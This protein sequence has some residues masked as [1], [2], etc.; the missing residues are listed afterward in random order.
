MKYFG[1]LPIILLADNKNTDT[2]GAGMNSELFPVLFTGVLI[3]LCLIFLLVRRTIR[4]RRVAGILRSANSYGLRPSANQDA[5]IERLSEQGFLLLSKIGNPVGRRVKYLLEGK[6]DGYKVHLFDYEVIHLHESNTLQSILVLESDRGR[7]PGFALVPGKLKKERFTQ[8]LRTAPLEFT[9]RLV[10]R[11]RKI[12]SKVDGHDLS[13]LPEDEHAVIDLFSE[14]LISY[15]SGR[16]K[17]TVEGKG[18]ALLIYQR[19]RVISQGDMEG[20]VKDGIS[21]YQSFSNEKLTK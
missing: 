17:Y 20:F 15:F 16:R 11:Y 19:E 4:K 6:V 9:S 14:E 7:F 18:K 10:S 1:I 21:I 5:A 3:F 12:H 13:C 8:R 2:R